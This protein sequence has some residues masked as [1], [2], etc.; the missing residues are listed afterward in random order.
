MLVRQ[1][2]RIARECF[3]NNTFHFQ[4]ESLMIRF[5]FQHFISFYGFLEEHLM[6]YDALINSI[7]Y[8]QYIFILYN[9]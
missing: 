1:Q 5:H 6:S 8:K 4:Y 9:Q 2:T 3:F 7:L